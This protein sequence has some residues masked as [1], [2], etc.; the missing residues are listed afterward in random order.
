MGASTISAAVQITNS[1]NTNQHCWE[2]MGHPPYLQQ[3]RSLTVPTPINT[4]G[5]PWG[6]HSICSSI[7]Y[8]QHQHCWDTMGSSTISAVVEVTNSINTNQHCWETM[9]HPLYLQEYRSHTA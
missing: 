7:D 4:A 9:G 6:I 3:Y 1:T 5:R 2:T 8:T